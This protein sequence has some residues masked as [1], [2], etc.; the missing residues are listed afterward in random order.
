MKSKNLL[1]AYSSN[2]RETYSA[3]IYRVCCAPDEYIIHFR[4]K[5][6][7][8]TS[9]NEE[10]LKGRKWREVVICHVVNKK[11]GHNQDTTIIPVRFWELIDIQVDTHTELVHTYIKLQKF[12]YKSETNEIAC[13]HGQMCFWEPSANS[14]LIPIGE[15]VLSWKDIVKKL[16]DKNPEHFWR[17][18][19]FLLK[20]LR[21]ASSRKIISWQHTEDLQWWYFSLSP[22]KYLIDLAIENTWNDGIWKLYL[23]SSSSRILFCTENPIKFDVEHDNLMLPIYIKPWA[24]MQ[25][26]EFIIIDTA[27]K[28]DGEQSLYASKIEIQVRYKVWKLILYAL[29]ITFFW[30]IVIAWYAPDIINVFRN[31]DFSWKWWDSRISLCYWIAIFLF[32]TFLSFL[33]LKS[34]NEKRW[35]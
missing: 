14:S 4:Y 32:S 21:S 23:K 27:Q 25:D 5:K 2:F 15:D 29:W 28:W 26:Y 22:N 17:K 3:D 11:E 34:F 6:K 31:F 9:D 33:L 19:F 18:V 10:T 8:C 12:A 35:F 20:S 13:L 24:V 7:Y 16:K 1:V 30:F